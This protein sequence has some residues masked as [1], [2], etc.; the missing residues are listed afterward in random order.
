MNETDPEL[1]KKA[2]RAQMI[3]Y[4]VM[5]IFVFL[6]FVLLWLQKRGVFG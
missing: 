6:P 3:L 2:D 1:A 4:G 5:I